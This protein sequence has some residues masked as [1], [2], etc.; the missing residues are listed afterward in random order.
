MV[1]SPLFSRST[2]ASLPDHF[3]TPLKLFSRSSQAH[4]LSLFSTRTALPRSTLAYP[5]SSLLTIG[6]ICPKSPITLNGLFSSSSLYG[7]ITVV[8]ILANFETTYLPK[9][10]VHPN[11]VTVCPERAERPPEGGPDLM[12]GARG[13]VEDGEGIKRS[14]ASFGEESVGVGFQEDVKMSC[15]CL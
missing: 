11:T 5:R 15:G 12:M 3:L 13:V 10:P 6:T 7:T 1:L 2:R 14:C 4:L 8:P 9:K